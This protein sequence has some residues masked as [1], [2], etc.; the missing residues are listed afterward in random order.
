LDLRVASYYRI[1]ML[2]A[3]SYF[4][5]VKIILVRFA[6][7]VLYNRR[8][9]K[10]ILAKLVSRIIRKCLTWFYQRRFSVMLPEHLQDWK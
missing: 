10:K 2:K 3:H 6:D 5:S 1:K 9:C 7:A 4:Q 8:C